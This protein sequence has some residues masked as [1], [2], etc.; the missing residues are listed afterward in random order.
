[1]F[2]SPPRRPPLRPPPRSRKIPAFQPAVPP[3][4]PPRS[5]EEPLPPHRRKEP[6]RA[7]EAVC[8]LRVRDLGTLQLED[9]K[10]RVVVRPRTRTRTLL[11][12]PLRFL[13]VFRWSRPNTLSWCRFAL[14]SL[15]DARAADALRFVVVKYAAVITV[16]PPATSSLTDVAMRGLLRSVL[17]MAQ[18]NVRTSHGCASALRRALQVCSNKCTLVSVLR[19]SAVCLSVCVQLALLRGT[20]VPNLRHYSGICLNSAG[21]ALLR[22]LYVSRDFTCTIT[23]TCTIQPVL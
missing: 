16:E 6:N 1:M 7:P 15:G 18:F 8:N 22:A 21:P 9:L 13:R 19:V 10:L 4:R 20:A 11:T 5:V 23:G 17:L 3:F 2:L 12:A 14:A